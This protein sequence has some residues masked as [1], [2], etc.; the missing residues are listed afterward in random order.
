MYGDK[1]DAA[2]L[3]QIFVEQPSDCR[4]THLLDPVMRCGYLALAEKID[5][6]CFEQGQLREGMPSNVL[7]MLGYMGFEMDKT[8]LMVAFMIE[9][10]KKRGGSSYVTPRVKRIFQQYLKA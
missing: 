8:K 7:H 10:V 4:C 6:F 2:A 9:D 1:E 5:H 3:F